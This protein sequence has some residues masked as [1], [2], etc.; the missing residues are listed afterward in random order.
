MAPGAPTTVV[1]GRDGM[2]VGRV[3]GE[4]DW[5]GPEARALVDKALKAG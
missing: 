1:Y 5:S 2:E 4:I 3:A